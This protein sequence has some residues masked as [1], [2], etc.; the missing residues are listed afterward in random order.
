MKG[1]NVSMKWKN[2]EDFKWINF[3][4]CEEEC[5]DMNEKMPILFYRLMQCTMLSVLSKTFGLEQASNYFRQAGLLAGSEFA[6][7][8]LDLTA[9]T[10]KFFSD[11]QK[12]LRDS[13]I[14]TLS[15]EDLGHGVGNIVFTAGQELDCKWA[16]VTSNNMSAYD[17]GFITGILDSYEGTN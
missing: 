13:K 2:N 9:E 4:N 14:G 6:K 11:L 3:G 1:K 12:T 15:I 7:N 17:E 16:P 10:N 8:A 5:G